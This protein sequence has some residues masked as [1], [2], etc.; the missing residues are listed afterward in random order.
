MDKIYRVAEQIC[1]VCGKHFYLKYCSDGTYEYVGKVC[2]CEADFRP[3][4][5][6]PSISEWMESL[7]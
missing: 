2:D 4:E 6:Q 5:G 1:S 3:I 7:K